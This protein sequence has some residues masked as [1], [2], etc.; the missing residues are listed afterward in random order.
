MTTYMSSGCSCSQ[1]HFLRFE[2]SHKQ[3]YA[4]PAIIKNAGEKLARRVPKQSVS[5]TPFWWLSGNQAIIT[6]RRR[7]AMRLPHSLTHLRTHARTHS[8]THSLTYSLTY[9]LTHSLNHPLTNSRPRS[10]PCIT[11][12]SWRGTAMRTHCGLAP[13]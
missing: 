1:H 13:P 12:G 4:C 9:S 7:P 10:E 8:L 3:R 6:E 5:T 11:L 2:A